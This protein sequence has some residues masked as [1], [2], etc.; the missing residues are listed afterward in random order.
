MSIFDW[1]QRIGSVG[2]VVR[3]AFKNYHQIHLT[4]PE[5]TEKDICELIFKVRYKAH[6]A[7]TT[8]AKERLES[9]QKNLKID[10]ILELCLQIFEIE[11]NVN[12]YLDA[13]L[14]NRTESNAKIVLMNLNKKYHT[15]YQ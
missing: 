2:S 3:W 4:N 5:L 6:I 10:S 9:I 15:N 13:D 12:P 1:L 8:G 11:M 14:F 7:M